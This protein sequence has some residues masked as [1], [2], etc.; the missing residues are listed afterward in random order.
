LGTPKSLRALETQACCTTSRRPVRSALRVPAVSEV[1]LPILNTD[2]LQ[3]HLVCP[4][5]G[6]SLRTVENA[7]GSRNL[8]EVSSDVVARSIL[9]TA[10]DP[11]LQRVRLRS[12]KMAAQAAIGFGRREKSCAP[13]RP[14]QARKRF[15]SSRETG[16]RLA[17]LGRARGGTSG[18]DSG[19]S[20]SRPGQ[21]EP[22]RLLTRTTGPGQSA[23]SSS[24]ASQQVQAAFFPCGSGHG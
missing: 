14:G 1:A 19:G 20:V 4:S 8:F 7:R 3:W 15:P 22:E 5:K 13:G 9:R 12:P 2:R 10:R 11:P 17:T 21:V 24:R 23:S 6:P 16:T 18:P